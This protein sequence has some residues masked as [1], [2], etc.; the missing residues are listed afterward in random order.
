M[1]KGNIV[2]FSKRKNKPSDSKGVEDFKKFKEAAVET[3]KITLPEGEVIIY[4]SSDEKYMLEIGNICLTDQVSF[5]KLAFLLL[6]ID[7][8]KIEP[9]PDV[10]DYIKK[11]VFT[12]ERRDETVLAIAELIFI[13]DESLETKEITVSR[14][15]DGIDIWGESTGMNDVAFQRIEAGLIAELARLLEVPL[16]TLSKVPVERNNVEY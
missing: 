6:R 2:D 16:S 4:K 9:K 14:I 12:M 8:S 13:D 1:V 15:Q 7:P 10:S 3:H 5:E 11:I